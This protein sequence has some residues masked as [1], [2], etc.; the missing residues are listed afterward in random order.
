MGPYSFANGVY[1]VYTKTIL[2]TRNIYNGVYYWQTSQKNKDFL[3]VNLDMGICMYL[4]HSVFDH[5]SVGIADH[6]SESV[7][8]CH[9]ASRTLSISS[10]EV[11]LEVRH[12]ETR[13]NEED[14]IWLD[15][16]G[17]T[18]VGVLRHVIKA[19]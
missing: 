18:L 6:R 5:D 17:V 9:R 11:W 2:F 16:W 13:H 7:C 19:L 1:S 8:V 3:Y 12:V 10:R 14:T 4:I 15:T